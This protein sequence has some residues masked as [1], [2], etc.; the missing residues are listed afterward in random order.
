MLL[1]DLTCY[2]SDR[3]RALSQM[4]CPIEIPNGKISP[5]TKLKHIVT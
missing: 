2:G 5:V 1:K 3:R 4:G